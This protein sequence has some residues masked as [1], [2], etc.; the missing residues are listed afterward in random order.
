MLQY[1]LLHLFGYAV[2]IDD[3]KNFRVSLP[4]I[5]EVCQDIFTEYEHSKST[6]SPPATLKLM[7]L[8]VLKSPPVRSVRVSPMPLVSLLRR[9]I[10]RVFST[11]PASI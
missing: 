9:R 10:P 3:L 2:S 5:A 8:L 7:T 1:A 6:A 11:S 4:D